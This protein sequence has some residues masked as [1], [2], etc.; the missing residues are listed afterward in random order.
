[1]VS[2]TVVIATRFFSMWGSDRREQPFASLSSRY[3]SRGAVQ[4]SIRRLFSPLVVRLRADGEGGE[5]AE[6]RGHL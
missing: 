1:M 4:D 5:V 3:A 6:A 2:A